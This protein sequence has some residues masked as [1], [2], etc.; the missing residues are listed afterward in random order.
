MARK[1]VWTAISY[2]PDGWGFYL[3]FRGGNNSTGY[4]AY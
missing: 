1:G 3:E 4:V 2:V